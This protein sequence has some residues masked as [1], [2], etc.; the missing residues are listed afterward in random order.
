MAN[1]FESLKVLKITSEKTTPM[2]LPVDLGAGPVVLTLAPAGEMNKPYFNETL[3]LMKRPEQVAR[4]KRGIQGVTIDSFSEKRDE[5]RDLFAKHV[6]RDWKN[7]VSPSGEV[8]AC[9]P[10]RALR[11]LQALPDDIVDEIRE[12]AKNVE[13]FRTTGF[14]EIAKN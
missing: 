8:L 1:E 13:N 3:R 7:V 14:L 9:E 2:T 4:I 12:F 11:F 6:I 5:D 10:D